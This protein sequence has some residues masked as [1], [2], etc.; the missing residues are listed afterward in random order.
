MSSLV[1]A[2]P[3]PEDAPEWFDFVVAQQALTYRGVVRPDFTEAQNAF[4]DDWVP[5]LAEDF[6]NPGTT[7][8]LI[9]RREGVVVGVVSITD[10]PADWEIEEGYL[11]APAPRCLDR[12]Y[13][14]PDVHGQGLGTRL[15]SAVDD[16]RDIYLWLI[17]ANTSAQ[18]FYRRK[19]FVD[20]EQHFTVGP[21]WGDVGMHRMVR[22]T[23]G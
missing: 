1:I 23:T 2:P 16:G 3:V 21:S 8:R 4:R 9:A 17:D 7:R 13:L 10:G 19:G 12:L 15:F 22:T 5:G 14:H 20:E 6:A 11:P 18:A